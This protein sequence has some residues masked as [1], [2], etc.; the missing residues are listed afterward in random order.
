[1]EDLKS[2]NS[3]GDC[4]DYL[5]KK[6]KVKFSQAY[7]GEKTNKK[8]YNLGWVIGEKTEYLKVGYRVDYDEKLGLHVNFE[9][10]KGGEYEH[11]LIKTYCVK[12]PKWDFWRGLG[13][14]YGISQPLY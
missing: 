8:M 12:N 3:L 9:G 10:G 13:R 4:I 1:M 7:I 2:F 5:E 11:C 6:Y 14:K